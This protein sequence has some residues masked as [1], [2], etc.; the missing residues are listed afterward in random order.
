MLAFGLVSY[1]RS[2]SVNRA[3]HV[4]NLHVW[5]GRRAAGAPRAERWDWVSPAGGPVRRPV[6]GAVGRVPNVTQNDSKISQKA[7]GSHRGD[8]SAA[9]GGR[10]AQPGGFQMGLKT[11]AT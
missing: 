10:P 7:M 4:K 9:R 6:P 8:A 2:S 5:S 3:C 1:S 11:I